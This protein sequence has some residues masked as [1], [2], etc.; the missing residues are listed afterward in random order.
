MREVDFELE[1]DPDMWCSCCHR[2]VTRAVRISANSE[3]S[4]LSELSVE[5]SQTPIFAGPVGRAEGERPGYVLICDGC[6][7][8]IAEAL[9]SDRKV[10]NSGAAE[11]RE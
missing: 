2:D 10:A 7:S 11:A 9:R 1:C 8:L 6:A 4:E 5:R 3:L